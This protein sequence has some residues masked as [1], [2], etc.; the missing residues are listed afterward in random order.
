MATVLIAGA[1]L[2]AVEV[3]AAEAASEGHTVLTEPDGYSAYETALSQSPDLVFLEG[4]MPLFDGYETCSLIRNDPSF[5]PRL[6][7]FVLVREDRDA[8]ALRR[9]HGTAFFAKD[10][11][12]HELRDLLA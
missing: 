12:V 1:D 4:R 7:V 9:C 10:H 6:P 3:L 5:S 8:P 11:A 2:A